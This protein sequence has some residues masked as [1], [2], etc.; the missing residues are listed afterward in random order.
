MRGLTWLWKYVFEMVTK[1]AACDR[2][3]RPSYVSLP[4]VSSPERSQWST[5]TLV[6][7][8]MVTASP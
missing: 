3:T 1:S 8:W 4:T 7:N 2:S 5:Q 6:D